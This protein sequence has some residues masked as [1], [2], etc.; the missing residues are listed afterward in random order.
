MG[1]WWMASRANLSPCQCWRPAHARQTGPLL[2][3]RPRVFG[4]DAMTLDQTSR[5]YPIDLRETRFV[6]DDFTIE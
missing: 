4:R 2:L 5:L 3:V 6:K 1:S